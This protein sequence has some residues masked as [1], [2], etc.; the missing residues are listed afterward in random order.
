MIGEKIKILRSEKGWNQTELAKKINVH[1]AVITRWEHNKVIP[2]SK[3]LKKLADVF[4]KPM[5]YFFEDI[6]N[7]EHN[8]QYYKCCTCFKHYN[9]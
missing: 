6:K 1:Q 3:N 5:V 8:C 7:E 4:E 2:E 9:K